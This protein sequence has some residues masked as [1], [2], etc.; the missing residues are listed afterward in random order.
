M[1]MTPLP[2]RPRIP[3]GEHQ[4]LVARLRGL[5][6]LLAHSVE[7][8]VEPRG[9]LRSAV[10]DVYHLTAPGAVTG[11]LQHLRHKQIKGERKGVRGEME[12]S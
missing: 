1:H 12:G 10:S 3:V 5:A 11:L 2:S 6:R 4:Q 8:V 9:A 7:G